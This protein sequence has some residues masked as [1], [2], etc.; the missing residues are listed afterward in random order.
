MSD[1]RFEALATTV[2]ELGL[3]GTL[4]ADGHALTADGRRLLDDG[5]LPDRPLR[6]L[7]T[8]SFS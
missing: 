3:A 2:H 8:R 4:Y 1:S 6:D 5:D 7:V